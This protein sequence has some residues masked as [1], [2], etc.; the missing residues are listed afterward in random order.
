RNGMAADLTIFNYEEIQ[1]TST[2]SEEHTSE[3]Q[4]RENLVC[5]LLLEKKNLHVQGATSLAS[6]GPPRGSLVASAH[7]ALDL[8]RQRLL[9]LQQPF[10]YWVGD[11]QDY[12]L[13]P[14]ES[15]LL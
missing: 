14:S 15:F 1:D 6:V 7:S 8:P 9:E 2:R 12:T 3:L 11:P 5:R 10:F 13:F 4:S